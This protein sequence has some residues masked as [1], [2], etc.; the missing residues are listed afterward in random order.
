MIHVS[1]CICM[2]V[3]V[4]TLNNIKKLLVSSGVILSN[5]LKD[6]NIHSEETKP[7]RNKLF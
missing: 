3:C 1:I 6:Y 2:L 7:I 4:C 5:F